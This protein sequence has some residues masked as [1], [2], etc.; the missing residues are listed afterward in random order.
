MSEQHRKQNLPP[1]TSRSQNKKSDNSDRPKL[2]SNAQ[3]QNPSINCAPTVPNQQPSTAGSGPSTSN[4]QPSTA[5]QH[6]PS[7]EVEMV[8]VENQLASTLLANLSKTGIER[9]KSL[10]EEIYRTEIHVLKSKIKKGKTQVNNLPEFLN[11]LEEMKNYTQEKLAMCEYFLEMVTGE[12]TDRLH[13]M[14]Y[15][16]NIIQEEEDKRKEYVNEGIHRERLFDKQREKLEQRLD[17]INSKIDFDIKTRDDMCAQ[18][19]ELNAS[20]S[21]IVP[22]IKE[23]RKS[24]EQLKEEISKFEVKFEDGDSL[25]SELT[26]NASEWVNEK[27]TAVGTLNFVL[28]EM[29]KDK[30]KVSGLLK[31][32]QR[33]NKNMCNEINNLVKE[34][35]DLE[36]QM[37]ELQTSSKSRIETAETEFDQKRTSHSAEA[38]KL[39]K[40][41]KLLRIELDKMQSQYEE[42]KR[43]IEAISSLRESVDSLNLKIGHLETEKW[44]LEHKISVIEEYINVTN[45]W[46][47]KRSSTSSEAKRRRLSSSNS[48]NENRVK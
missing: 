5:P 4:K 41:T 35:A 27:R 43:T 20:E 11:T 3:P 28:S 24:N 23:F 13:N 47:N 36:E 38:R 40:D 42:H 48:V 29:K 16:L 37:T 14:N 44:K 34:C 17:Q 10:V 9:N 25:A 7:V 33:A 30:K 1:R 32:E 26:K 22:T 31:K 8:E 19:S 46:R 2:M 21:R 12:Y 39:S 45:D 18:I 15:M 6:P